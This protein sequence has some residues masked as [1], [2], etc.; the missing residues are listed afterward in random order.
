MT[1]KPI[2]YLQQITNTNVCV[3]DFQKL[4]FTLTNNWKLFSKQKYSVS[5]G[6]EVYVRPL[7]CEKD[8]IGH[9]KSGLS[10]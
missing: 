3:K 10:H 7:M 9:P 8:F 2:S 5:S 6:N 1:T 4:H